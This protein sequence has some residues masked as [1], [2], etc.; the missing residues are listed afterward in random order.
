[1]LQ[2]TGDC[3]FSGCLAAAGWFHVFWHHWILAPFFTIIQQKVQWNSLGFA[4]FLE[5]LLFTHHHMT[6]GSSWQLEEQ[7]MRTPEL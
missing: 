4:K 7:E 6:P 2:T 5:F 3:L 1:M